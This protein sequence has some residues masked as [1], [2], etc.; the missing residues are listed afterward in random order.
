[1][2]S[3]WATW[4]LVLLSGR[5]RRRPMASCWATWSRFGLALK[6]LWLL[7]GPLWTVWVLHWRLLRVTWSHLGQPLAAF[8]VSLGPS[9]DA[10]GE[11]GVHLGTQMS[12]Y[13]GRASKFTH[14]TH[15]TPQTTS[16]R[17]IVILL[18]LDKVI[19][20]QPDIS[21]L[22]IVILLPRASLCLAQESR[23]AARWFRV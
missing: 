14:I 13:A 5:R 3:C 23:S 6:P 9:W 21:W 22:C 8:G 7:L 15:L 2:A 20:S 16:W 12:P 4:V 18:H 19:L 1:M 11:A 10:W 17:W